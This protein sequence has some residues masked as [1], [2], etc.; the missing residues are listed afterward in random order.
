MVV[1]AHGGRDPNAAE[2][3]VL[4]GQLVRIAAHEADMVD[5]RGRRRLVL[6]L[7]VVPDDEPVMLVVEA[8]EG[9]ELVAEPHV[10]G[11][12]PAIP[13]D[14]SVDVLGAKAEMSDLK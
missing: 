8:H 14:G 1:D 4:L 9:G 11:E 5:S 10:C 12:S 13:F 6:G 3:I 7:A 2:P